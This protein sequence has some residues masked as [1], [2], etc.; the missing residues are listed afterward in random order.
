VLLV[1]NAYFCFSSS[2]AP[3]VA[4]L[5]CAP[6]VLAGAH[7]KAAFSSENDRVDAY[8]K[9]GYTWPPEDLKPNSKGALS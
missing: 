7:K 9:K 8:H 5:W 1:L 6:A 3:I 4:L 2:A